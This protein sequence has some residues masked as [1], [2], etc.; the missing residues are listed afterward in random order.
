M[1]NYIRVINRAYWPSEDEISKGINIDEIGANTI[2]QELKT[3]DNTLS[4]WAVENPEDVVLAMI[5]NASRIDDMYT[6]KIEDDILYAKKL[7]V[8]NDH[9]NSRIKELNEFHYNIRDLNYKKLA[10]VAG[11][12]I[13]A[14][15]EETNLEVFTK[16]D[17]IMILKKAIIEK[18]VAIQDLHKKIREEI[19]KYE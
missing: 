4:L 6:L 15:R 14:L 17:I 19:E 16:K 1:A 2:T 8:V 11:A 18:R 3:K 5:S 9:A 12:I 13:E 7:N 10:D